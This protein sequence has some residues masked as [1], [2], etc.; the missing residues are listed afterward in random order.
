MAGFITLRARLARRRLAAQ[1]A[2]PPA[3]TRAAS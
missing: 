1:L 3:L 2:P